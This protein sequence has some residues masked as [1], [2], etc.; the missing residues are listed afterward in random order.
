MYVPPVRDNP[1]LLRDAKLFGSQYSSFYDEMI[2]H[3]DHDLPSYA[4]DNHTV[5]E[6][7][8]KSFKENPLLMSSICPHQQCGDG[9]AAFHAVMLHNMGNIT[10]DDLIEKAINKITIKGVWNG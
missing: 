3:T 1:L 6:L 2:A 7:L 10:W 4:A 5:M 9:R 8:M